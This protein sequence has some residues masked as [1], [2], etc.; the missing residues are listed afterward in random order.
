LSAV[1]VS[2]VAFAIVLGGALLGA[3]LR[4]ALPK[5]H[6]NDESKDTIKVGIG[7]I[8]TLAAL[9]LG[10]LVAS[11]KSSYDTKSEEIKESAAKIIVLDR[12]LRQYGPE[13][14]PARDALQ[15]AITSRVNLTWVEFDNQLESR[16]ASEGAPEAGTAEEFQHMLTGLSP[17]NDGQRAIQSRALQ[18]S[19]DLAQ[20]RWLLFT[21]KGSSI[22]TP[23]L[24]V[25]VLWLSVIFGSLGLFAPRNATV[26]SVVFVCALS[27]SGAIFLILEMDRPFEGLLKISDAPLRSAIDQLKR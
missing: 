11:A 27:V 3:L 23:F 19:S 25:L 6:L 10:L 24:V 17:A 8:A 21:Q 18:L 14:K 26:Y 4:G 20:T 7:L 22:P 13:T 1:A 9:V 15:R 12:S 5:H 2:L 16:A